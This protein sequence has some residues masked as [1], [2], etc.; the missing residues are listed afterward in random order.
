MTLKPPLWQRDPTRS[1]S[2][3]QPSPPAALLCAGAL[4]LGAALA[5]GP[6]RG[7]SGDPNG[8]AAPAAENPPASDGPERT[9]SLAERLREGTELVDQPGSF[10]R[11]GD[12]IAFFTDMGG[13]RFVVLENLALERV[14]LAIAD[15]PDPIY[16]GVDGIVTEYG[17]ENF[18]LIH[19]AVRRRKP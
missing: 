9:S 1:P 14:G 17:G 15:H 7:A 6:T 11:T 3:G 2:S 16:W 18:L 5:L 4:L 8:S 12:R 13:G 10:R 19:R